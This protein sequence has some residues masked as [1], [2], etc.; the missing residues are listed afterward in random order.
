MKI[1]L[2]AFAVV[3]VSLVMAASSGRAGVIYD[4]L[5]QPS[6]GG[7]PVKPGGGVQGP[8]YDSFSTGTGSGFLLTDV[9]LLLFNTGVPSG[10][11]SIGIYDTRTLSG[12]AV[13]L[14]DIVATIG[15]VERL[16]P[17]RNREC[18]E[19]LCRI[20]GVVGRECAVL[21]RALDQRQCK[22]LVV[23]Y[24][25]Q[26]R[27]RRRRGVPVEQ[28]GHV[29]HVQYHRAVSDG[30]LRDGRAGTRRLWGGPRRS[31]VRRLLDLAATN[32]SKRMPGRDIGVPRYP[33][34][35]VLIAFMALASGSAL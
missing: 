34:V 29:S 13:V 7:D 20:P 22:R 35:R 17:E 30:G 16:E 1:C 28:P 31:G 5:G 18:L 9:Q 6:G 14:G 2:A 25:E 23:V 27:H 33:S 12:G 3:T 21:G 19:R 24:V 32:P 26:R 8:L 11:T 4:N 10:S 15:T